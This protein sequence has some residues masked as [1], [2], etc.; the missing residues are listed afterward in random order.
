MSDTKK[1]PGTTARAEAVKRLI[2]LHEDEFDSLI[3]DE[4]GKRNLIY[5]K[6]ETPEQKA[7]RRQAEKNTKARE[8]AR[9]AFIDAGLPVPPGLIDPDEDAPEA[10]GRGTM[11]TDD[12]L[13]A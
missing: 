3:S 2:A 1:R 6:Q 7:E 5:V 4:Y 10:K 12:E 8:K 13:S 11:L 9:K